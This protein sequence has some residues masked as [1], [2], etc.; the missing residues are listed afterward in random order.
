MLAIAN[1]F[2][3][4]LKNHKIFLY[5]LPPSAVDKVFLFTGALRGIKLLLFMCDCIKFCIGLSEPNITGDQYSLVKE[6]LGERVGSFFFFL[7]K[8]LI[9]NSFIKINAN[10]FRFLISQ[11]I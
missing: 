2:F 1:I 9:V 10:F 4:L 11:V 5:S 8:G 6:Y 3:L 7:K